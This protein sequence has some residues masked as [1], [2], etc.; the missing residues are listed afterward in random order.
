MAKAK[1]VDKKEL[2]VEIFSYRNIVF[3]SFR[4]FDDSLREE[5]KFIGKDGDE[6][7]SLRIPEIG[8]LRSEEGIHKVKLWTPGSNREADENAFMLSLQDDIHAFQVANSLRKLV[9]EYNGK[10]KTH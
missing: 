3:G 8:I 5:L 6:I 9:N 4:G 1:E 2:N 7:E 10:I